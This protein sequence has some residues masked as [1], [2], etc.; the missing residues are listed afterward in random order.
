MG[1]LHALVDGGTP[2]FKAGRR[3]Y[4]LEVCI[5]GIER[6]ARD[7]RVLKVKDYRAFQSASIQ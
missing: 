3:G 2:R 6:S 4:I 1:D 7:T 5:G